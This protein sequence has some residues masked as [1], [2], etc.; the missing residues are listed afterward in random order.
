MRIVFA[1]SHGVGNG[2]Q[3][4]LVRHPE[5]T[6]M[7]SPPIRGRLE[8]QQRDR[9]RGSTSLSRQMWAWHDHSLAR[10]FVRGSACELQC[11]A[12][13]EGVVQAYLGSAVKSAHLRRSCWPR[14]AG[15]WRA[16]SSSRRRSLRRMTPPAAQNIEAAAKDRFAKGGNSSLRAATLVTSSVAFLCA[17]GL[18]TGAGGQ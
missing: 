12:W 17:Q 2:R 9:R 8:D 1:R 7:R 10:A 11:V 15:R 13:R 5:P 16:S 14:R 4:A 6:G 3:R 18:A